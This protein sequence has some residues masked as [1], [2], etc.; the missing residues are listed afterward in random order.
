MSVF[1]IYKIYFIIDIIYE[2]IKNNIYNLLN[3]DKTNL[4]SFKYLK[5]D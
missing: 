3:Y 4:S 5:R 2:I 1:Q